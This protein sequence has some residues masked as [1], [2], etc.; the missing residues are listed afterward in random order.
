MA[1]HGDRESFLT[2][3]KPKLISKEGGKKV[4]QDSITDTWDAA[5]M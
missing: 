5:G 3:N 4:C 2:E 1:S